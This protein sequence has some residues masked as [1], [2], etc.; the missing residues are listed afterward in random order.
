MASVSYHMLL[1]MSRNKALFSDLDLCVC[2]CVRA[3]MQCR[4]WQHQ[5]THLNGANKTHI[6]HTHAHI[7]DTCVCVCV[8]TD[9]C[10][11]PEHIPVTQIRLTSLYTQRRHKCR[12]TLL[13]ANRNWC[14]RTDTH[15]QES[16]Q[17]SVIVWVWRLLAF[18][19]LSA[20]IDLLEEA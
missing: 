14:T 18:A 7:F 13:T 8:R 1:Q 2:V 11:V 3:K 15:D 17:H 12:N 9:S 6:S 16:I 19:N 5:N 4:T 10:R 20:C